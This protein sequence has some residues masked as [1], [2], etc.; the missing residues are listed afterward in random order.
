LPG[1]VCREILERSA[2]NH[3]PR[4]AAGEPGFRIVEDTVER[5]HHDCAAAAQLALRPPQTSACL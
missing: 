4:Q 2:A 5:Q 3:D 1:G